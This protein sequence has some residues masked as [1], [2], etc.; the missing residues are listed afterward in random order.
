MTDIDKAYIA[1]LFDGEG[2]VCLILRKVNMKSPKVMLLCT[3]S[4]T[5]K[6]VLLWCREV[7]GCGSVNLS[8]ETKEK[9]RQ[10][11]SLFSISFKPAMLF[12]KDILPFLK[13]KK[14]RAILAI[15][16][17]EERDFIS[18]DEQML[19]R[20]EMKKLNKGKGK[21]VPSP[22]DSIEKIEL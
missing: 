9:N 18:F 11:C 20:N 14:D 10:P 5:N 6:N 12:L 22:E 2:C 19:Y 16:F 1:G 7:I 3:I 13:I 15:K 21:G 17:I 4:N 8:Y